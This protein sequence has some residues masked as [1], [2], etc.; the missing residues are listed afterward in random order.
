[1]VPLVCVYIFTAFYTD[2]IKVPHISA[3]ML[4]V[5]TFIQQ[6][7]STN[8]RSTTVGICG[9]VVVC[10]TCTVIHNSQVSY[11]CHRYQLFP[12]TCFSNL[13]VQQVSYK[14]HE[15]LEY[16]VGK[17]VTI[18]FYQIKIQTQIR[19]HLPRVLHSLE[20]HMLSISDFLAVKTSA[21]Q[22]A[23]KILSG[24]MENNSIPRKYF[25]R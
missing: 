10:D 14:V 4:C 13:Y 7:K 8:S 25:T 2:T 22:L 12:P 1:M 5:G 3:N 18:H 9:Q 19:S 17:Q 11:Q 21:H 15:Q 23:Y 24:Y 20:N 6:L 16:V